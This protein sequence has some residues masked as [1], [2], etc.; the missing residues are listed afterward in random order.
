MARLSIEAKQAIVEKVF[1][2]DGRT[3]DE[4]ANANNISKSTLTRWVKSFQ[5]SCTMKVQEGKNNQK[6]SVSERFEHI[7]AT[8]SLEEIAVGAYCREHGIYSFQ[9]AQWKEAFM[10]Q[11]DENIAKNKAIKTELALWK[12]KAKQLEQEIQRKDKALAEV[13]ALLILKKKAKMIW[14]VPEED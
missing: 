5:N 2:R 3:V 14:G 1:A 4:I 11:S 10:A 13:S 12:E 7:I 6:L 8:A 9:L